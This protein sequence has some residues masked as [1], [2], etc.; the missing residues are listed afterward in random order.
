MNLHTID[1]NV[2]IA[3]AAL[4]LAVW[5]IALDIWMVSRSRL[6]G[7]RSEKGK[8]AQASQLLTAFTMV[9]VAVV[10]AV[11]LVVVNKGLLCNYCGR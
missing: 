2:L 7:A 11:A 6:Q 5:A 1:P 8:K 3:G 4:L 10:I 9:F